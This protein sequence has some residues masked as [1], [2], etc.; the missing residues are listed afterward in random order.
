MFEILDCCSNGTLLNFAP[1]SKAYNT[2][3]QPR[4]IERALETPYKEDFAA[5]YPGLDN[6]ERRCPLICAVFNQNER[7]LQVLVEKKY[8]PLDGVFLCGGL[9]TTPLHWAIECQAYRNQQYTGAIK[10]LLELGFSTNIRND[11]GYTPLHTLMCHEPSGRWEVKMWHCAIIDLLMDHGADVEIETEIFNDDLTEST[12]LLMAGLFN[13]QQQSV[14]WQLLKHGAS[15]EYYRDVHGYPE[16][17]IVRTIVGYR[18]L[19]NWEMGS[20]FE[21]RI[22]GYGWIDTTD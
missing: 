4:L 8:F 20:R 2:I 21:R 16:G 11:K 18:Q 12:P 10:Q 17:H 3:I 1:T 22:C 15:W 19:I 9:K 13:Q 7:L 5:K 14:V 6:H